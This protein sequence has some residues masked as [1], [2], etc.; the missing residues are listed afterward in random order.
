MFLLPLLPPGDRQTGKDDA[1]HLPGGGGSLLRWSQRQIADRVW[2]GGMDTASHARLRWSGAFGQRSRLTARGNGGLRRRL[3]GAARP[4]LWPES[5]ETRQCGRPALVSPASSD[6]DGRSARAPCYLSIKD[7]VFDRS[8]SSSPQCS[9]HFVSEMWII[10]SSMI[11]DVKER[12]AVS[13]TAS[14]RHGGERFS[15]DAQGLSRRVC[16]RRGPT[17][18]ERGS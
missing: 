16:R 13:S 15:A 18:A 14:V 5:H 8:S 6:I 12:T 7:P 10:R 2:I 9:G 17:R 11:V 3:Q 1:G 4:S